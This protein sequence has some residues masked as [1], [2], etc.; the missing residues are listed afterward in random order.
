MDKCVASE[1]QIRKIRNY[2]P[3]G[4][5]GLQGSSTWTLA[6]IP[7][8][9]LAY[10]LL[11]H[12]AFGLI[13]HQRLTDVSVQTGNPKYAC[14]KNQ[15]RL[16]C[17][18]VNCSSSNA[19]CCL[20]SNL[21][22]KWGTICIKNIHFEWKLLSFIQHLKTNILILLNYEWFTPIWLLMWQFLR[23]WP[24]EHNCNIQHLGTINKYRESLNT[25]MSNAVHQWPCVSI[26]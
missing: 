20:F 10:H 6:N 7:V 18:G 8:F 17:G 22:T 9:R 11:E 15:K 3:S 5:D 23:H 4:N 13:G 12:G 16:D 19:L 26:Y 1:I 24:M 2:F 25:I 21:T 14:N